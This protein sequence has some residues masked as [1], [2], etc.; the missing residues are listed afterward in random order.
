MNKRSAEVNGITLS[1]IDEGEGYP[2]LFCH[3]FPE[4]SYSWRNQIKYFASRGYRVVAVDMPGYG[5]ST[6]PESPDRLSAIKVVG[7]L[8][9][10]L[11]HL[12]INDTVIIGNDWGSTISWQAARMRPDLF[13]AIVAM[14]VPFMARAPFL[15]TSLFPSN[16]DELF[17]TLYFQTIGPAEKEFEKDVDETISKIY[18][19]ASGGAGK[20]LPGDNTPNPFSMVS[21]KEGLLAT[22]PEAGPMPWLSDEDKKTFVD[23]FKKSGFFGGLSYYRNLD[24][25]WENEAAFDGVKVSVPALFLVGERDTGLSIPGMDK[26]IDSMDTFV[27]QLWGSYIIPEGGHWLPQEKP[28]EVNSYIEKFLNDIKA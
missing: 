5:D 9:A 8:V 12:D 21:R 27:P 26:I 4:T 20:R 28:E 17:Y 25:N 15:P 13:T 16:N 19:A 24:T 14:G 10:L 2:L 6:V 3:G 11:I 23:T 7:D 1:F 18:F 22:L